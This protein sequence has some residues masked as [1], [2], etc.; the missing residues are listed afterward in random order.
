[1]VPTA[2]TQPVFTKLG[3]R[4][5]CQ[6]ASKQLHSSAADAV[7]VPYSM[8]TCWARMSDA[9]HAAA[10][11]LL[12]VASSHAAVTHLATRNKH[13][14]QQYLYT[15]TSTKTCVQTK[16]AS[17]TYWYFL[18]SARQSSA[19]LLG[20]AQSPASIPSCCA[21]SGILKGPSRTF[22]TAL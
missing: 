20:N 7:V 2:E 21:S 6:A 13:V 1:M 4:L 14:Q 5:Q 9:T 16:N 22:T 3:Y 17:R 15:Y 8:L 19:I 11:L 10:Q 18:M 12:L